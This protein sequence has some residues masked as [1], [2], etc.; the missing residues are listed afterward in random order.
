ME[1]IRFLICVSLILVI[2]GGCNVKE[3]KSDSSE[4]VEKFYSIYREEKDPELRHYKIKE[5]IRSL[6]AKSRLKVARKIIEDPYAVISYYGANILIEEGYEDE[7]VP[8]LADMITSGRDKTKD[9]KG[10]EHE[11]GFGYDWMHH[12][13]ETLLRRMLFKIFRYFIANLE[14][15][16]DQERTRAYEI[17]SSSL[18]LDPKKPFT[19]DAAEK[20]MKKSKE[21]NQ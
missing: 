2:F 3:S 8:V 13:D 20:A 5:Y 9:E 11:W 19:A 17:M 16:T 15:Y 10:I 21:I 6:D 18:Q 1:I 14:R 4:L 7:A 12:E